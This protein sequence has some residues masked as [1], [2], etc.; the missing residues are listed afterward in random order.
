[1]P[2]RC[3]RKS[4]V[5]HRNSHSLACLDVWLAPANLKTPVAHHASIGV[6]RVLGAGM[7]AS[8][9]A[10]YVRGL[11][12]VGG[13]EYNPLINGVRPLDGGGVTQYTSW[14]QSWYR[15]LLVSIQERL[16]ARSQFLAAYT[17]SKAED[18]ATDY[19]FLLPQDNGFGRNPADPA[20]LPL[21]FNPDSERGPSLQDER[22]RFVLSGEYLLPRRV[23]VS[24]IVTVGSGRP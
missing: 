24:G 4:D 20:G 23:T 10:V 17:L 1:M 13:L 9:R 21:G 6:D 3:R 11:D 14:A 2:R 12:Q 16:G 5:S 7:T 19:A 18:T 8:V 15:G 22:H